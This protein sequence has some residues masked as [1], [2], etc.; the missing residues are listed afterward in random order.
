LKR[1]NSLLTWLDFQDRINPNC[2]VLK[3]LFAKFASE[4]EQ[5]ALEMVLD[6]SETLYRGV[7]Q[8]LS[9]DARVDA[10][11]RKYCVLNELLSAHLSFLSCLSK[12]TKVQRD[13][14]DDH[15]NGVA[16]LWGL[17]EEVKE[18]E[19]AQ[20]LLPRVTCWAGTVCNRVA[21]LLRNESGAR[22]H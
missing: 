8:L 5:K 10:R 9:T 17:V 13:H 22:D 4:D 20:P 21:L 16:G 3:P 2:E 1:L 15:V 7:E 12:K 19:R 18:R 14:M 6:I 11:F